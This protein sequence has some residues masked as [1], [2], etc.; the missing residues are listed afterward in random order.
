MWFSF[1][2]PTKLLDE[3]ISLYFLWCGFTEL[4]I[5]TQGASGLL[6]TCFKV[7]DCGKL[8]ALKIRTMLD[9]TTSRF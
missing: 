6:D 3:N 8:L 1:G 2:L 4:N 9:S 5:P 7:C